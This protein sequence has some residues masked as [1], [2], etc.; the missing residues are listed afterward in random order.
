MCI[1][2]YDSAQ[3]QVVDVKENSDLNLTLE[4]NESYIYNVYLN[5]KIHP[6]NSNSICIGSLICTSVKRDVKRDALQDTNQE[7]VKDSVKDSAKDKNKGCN[8]NSFPI[9]SL[10]SNSLPL[11]IYL[12]CPQDAKVGCILP[13]KYIIQN[14]TLDSHEISLV[15]ESLDSFV[16]SGYKSYKTRI[17]PFGSFTLLYH[18]IPLN[19]GKCILPRLNV[20]K[21]DLEF[22]QVERV[23]ED[24]VFVRP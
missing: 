14:S 12:E 4:P 24:C 2:G 15:M 19:S 8:R 7:S 9:P 23:G 17:L 20:M 18:F 22:K 21:G 10:N 16:Y 6:L 11:V 13:I 1:Q 5:C 3:I